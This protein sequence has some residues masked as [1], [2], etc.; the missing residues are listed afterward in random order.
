MIACSKSRGAGLHLAE[1]CLRKRF[2]KDGVP[3]ARTVHDQ[4]A[5]GQC[6]SSDLQAKGGVNPQMLWQADTMMRTVME[7]EATR[8]RVELEWEKLALRMSVQ[9]GRPGKEGRGV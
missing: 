3:G 2:E 6:S 1:M 8:L 9:R 4:I 5:Q 7:F